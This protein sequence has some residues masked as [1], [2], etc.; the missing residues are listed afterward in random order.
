MRGVSKTDVEVEVEVVEEK[1][2]AEEEVMVVRRRGGNGEARGRLLCCTGYILT[3]YTYLYLLVYSSS[4]TFPISFPPPLSSS[5]A[6][7]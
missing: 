6:L 1:R 3:I 4:C 7:W 5:H 2:V